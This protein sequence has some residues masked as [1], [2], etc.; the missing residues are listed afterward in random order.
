MG[1]AGGTGPWPRTLVPARHSPVPSVPV[2]RADKLLSEAVLSEIA[3]S[4]PSA[5]SMIG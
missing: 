3:L 2:P 5:P 1:R 4:T